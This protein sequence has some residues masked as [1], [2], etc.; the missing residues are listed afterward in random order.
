VT[1]RTPSYST[2]SLGDVRIVPGDVHYAAAFHRTLDAVA[3]E[4]R[5]LALT[6]APPIEAV[7]DFIERVRSKG[8]VELFAVDSAE[9]VVGWCDILRHDRDGFRHCGQLGMGI[10]VEFRGL[11][12]GG[13]LA[14]M[15]IERAWEIGLE[16]IELE[17]F[18]SNSAALQL[19]RGL[20]FVVEGTK[21]AAR[22]LDGAA[23]DIV[24]MARTH[25]P[26]GAMQDL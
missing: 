20:E 24:I 26:P 6:S 12:L 17:V 10:L 14:R 15:A 22:K 5:Y 25:G 3:R 13:R 4:R 23:D 18:A 9:R 2:G 7:R 19:Y 8:D 16:R 21:R 1:P 11:G